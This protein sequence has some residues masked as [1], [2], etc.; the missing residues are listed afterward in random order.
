MSEKVCEEVGWLPEK[1]K[2]GGGMRLCVSRWVGGREGCRKI[3]GWL[4]EGLGIVC[5]S[6]DRA[7]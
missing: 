4:P 5:V 3:L 2:L 1:L 6:D 7:C